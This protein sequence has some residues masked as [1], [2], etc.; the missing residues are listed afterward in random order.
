MEVIENLYDNIGGKIKNLAKWCFIVEAIGAI[1]TGF[2]LIFASSKNVLYG[3]LTIIG[4][5]IIAW[6]SSWLLYAAGELVEKTCDNERNT[7]EI[8][9]LMQG[10]SQEKDENKEEKTVVPAPKPVV[11]T[12]TSGEVKTSSVRENIS[13]EDKAPYWCGKCGQP[14]PFEGNCFNCGSSI[15]IFRGK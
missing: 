15:K 11:S 7:R 5:P 2:T 10:N 6:V 13:T 4:G 9:K 8:L 3:F 12:D 14:G 1:I